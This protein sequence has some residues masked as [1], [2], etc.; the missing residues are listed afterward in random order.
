V[1][2]ADETQEDYERTST[3]RISMETDSF[4]PLIITSV[5]SSRHRRLQ[6]DGRTFP[7]LPERSHKPF[8]LVTGLGKLDHMRVSL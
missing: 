1:S 7:P 4:A 2:E 5:G 3:P 6:R 8:V